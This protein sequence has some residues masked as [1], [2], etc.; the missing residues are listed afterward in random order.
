MSLQ[1][2]R[3]TSANSCNG[4]S[5]SILDFIHD[6]IQDLQQLS[7]RVAALEISNNGD[8]KVFTKRSVSVSR[9]RKLLNLPRVQP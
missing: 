8:N 5:V 7:D 1:G 2:G 4:N 6:V 9:H 3:P